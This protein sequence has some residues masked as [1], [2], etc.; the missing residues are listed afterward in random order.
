MSFVRTG[1]LVQIGSTIRIEPGPALI[2]AEATPELL[3]DDVTAPHYYAGE[4]DTGLVDDEGN[5]VMKKALDALANPIELGKEMSYLNWVGFQKGEPEQ[6]FYLYQLQRP[7]AAEKKERES[8]EPFYREIG[9]FDTEEEAISAG[10]ALKPSV[11]LGMA[12]L[13]DTYLDNGLTALKAAADRIYVCSAEPATF[14]AATSTVA[15]GNKTLAAGGVFPAAIAAG[16]PSGRK[17]TTVVVTDG[18]VTANGLA[19]HFAVVTFGSSRLDYA[20]SLTA[21]QQLTSGN[22]F[23]LAAADLRLPNFGG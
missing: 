20:N 8:D 22:T 13:N 10:L 14:T 16:S 9:V 23:T 17:V 2:K 7:T 4:R 5:P 21:T 6:D 3:A 18:T 19:S 12:F 1:S 11:E 15:L